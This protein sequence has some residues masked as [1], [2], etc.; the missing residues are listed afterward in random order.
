M[1][2]PTLSAPPTQAKGQPQSSVLPHVNG[3]AFGRQ[4]PRDKWL[5]AIWESDVLTANERCVAYV[6]ARYAGKLDISWCVWDELRKRSGI[7]SRDAINRA[8]KGLLAGGWLELTEPARQ[9]YSARYRLTIPQQSAR[10]TPEPVDGAPSSTGNGRLTGRR[11]APVVRETDCPVVRETT[12][13]VRETDPSTQTQSSDLPPGCAPPPDPRGPEHASRTRNE[14][15]E[16][17]TAVPDL[18][19]TKRVTSQTRARIES[20]NRPLLALIENTDPITVDDYQLTIPVEMPAPPPDR[21]RDEVLPALAAQ[22]AGI[23]ARAAGD[24]P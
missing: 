4:W 19:D 3:T 6:Y 8:I 9:H 16:P 15:D 24:H 7:K 11:T 23:N 22:L 13:V 20:S 2:A 21:Y 18:N 14:R 12:P 1:T 17:L 5:E 10:R